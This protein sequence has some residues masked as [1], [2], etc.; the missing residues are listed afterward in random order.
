MGSKSNAENVQKWF[1]PVEDNEFKMYCICCQ[2]GI[3]KE[4]EGLYNHT[5]REIHNK[6]KK[7]YETEQENQRLKQQLRMAGKELDEAFEEI[8]VHRHHRDKKYLLEKKDHEID[9][10]KKEIEK[11][12]S[13]PEDLWKAELD[14]E[15]QPLLEEIERLQKELYHTENKVRNEFKDKIFEM[16]EQIDGDQV[17]KQNAQTTIAELRKEL[18]EYKMREEYINKCR[19]YINGL[20]CNFPKQPDPLLNLSWKELKQE[21]KRL[22][23]CSDEIEYASDMEMPERANY[24]IKLIREKSPI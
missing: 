11:L 21:A 19:E 17:H 10:L 15:K 23:I 5:Q 13:C 16:Q 22:R 7:S 14:A 6:F 9:S 4:G 1:R 20:A 12:K 2:K 24:M 8:E 3:S 18:S